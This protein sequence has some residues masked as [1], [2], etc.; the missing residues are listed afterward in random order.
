M[1]Q[2]CQGLDTHISV[3]SSVLLAPLD[4]VTKL[5]ESQLTSGNNCKLQIC[6][7]YV[8]MA[9]VIPAF[10]F[11]SP[12]IYHGKYVSDTYVNYYLDIRT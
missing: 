5:I 2:G 1:D 9:P 8:T 7:S 4:K 11:Y 10:K 6:Y 3:N 12:I